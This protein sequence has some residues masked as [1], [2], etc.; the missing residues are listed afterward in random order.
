[1]SKNICSIC[2]EELEENV[3][4]CG[5]C[6]AKVINEEIETQQVECAAET[7]KEESCEQVQQC[8]CHECCDAVEETAP[9]K[10]EQSEAEPVNE[11]SEPKPAKPNPADQIPNYRQAPPFVPVAPNAGGFVN[12]VPQPGFEQPDKKSKYA[13]ISVAG[14]IGIFFLMMIPVINIILLIVWSCGGC[15]KVAKTQ[16]ARAALIMILIC[17]VIIIALVLVVR[18][19]IFPEIVDEIKY[20]YGI[21]ISKPNALFDFI[22]RYGLEDFFRAFN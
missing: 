17:L 21:D 10:D 2:G 19:V 18:F 12:R 5:S 22:D 1:M 8:E 14:W 15:R 16:F 4:F 13:G 3:K 11:I 9:V 20:E 7:E 6:G